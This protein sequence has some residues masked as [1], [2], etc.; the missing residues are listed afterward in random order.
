MTFRPFASGASIPCAPSRPKPLHGSP[1]IATISA[2][3]K[4]DACG[5]C[6][7]THS[8]ILHFMLPSWRM[9]TRK[10]QLEDLIALPSMTKDDVM[11]AWDQVATDRDLHLRDVAA[12]LDGLLSGEKVNAHLRGQNYAAATGGSSGK[13]GVFLWDWKPLSSP[14]TS[15]TGW[16]LGRTFESDGTSAPL[17]TLLATPALGGFFGLQARVAIR[18]SRC[19]TSGP[20]FVTLRPRKRTPS[21]SDSGP[22]PRRAQSDFLSVSQYWPARQIGAGISAA[23]ARSRPGGCPARK[24]PAGFL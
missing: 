21:A 16:R 6:L 20:S 10:F 1:G 2:R 8:V 15:P 23:D 24:Y 7:R 18:R 14:P 13:R 3:N 19:L 4:C 5:A 12:H 11:D 17:A 9:S 22:T